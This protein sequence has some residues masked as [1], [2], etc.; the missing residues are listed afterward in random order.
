MNILVVTNGH[1]EDQLAVCLV[2]RAAR[3]LAV[4]CASKPFL[5]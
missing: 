3:A 5:W 1:G 2:E 4:D